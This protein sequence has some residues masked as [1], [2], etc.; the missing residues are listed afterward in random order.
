MAKQPHELNAAT[1]FRVS[2]VPDLGLVCD[3][4]FLLRVYVLRC[5]GNCFYVG[6]TPTN[7]LDRIQSQFEG[8]ASHFCA[9]NR[10]IEVVALLPAKC[11]AIEAA[12]FYGM[13]QALNNK[14]H[15]KLGGFTQ[16]SAKPSPLV[17]MQMEMASPRF[18]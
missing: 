18:A 6:I 3:E 8:T 14:D 9:V 17:V 13:Q 12:L 15:T 16:T 7:K 4:S 2:P 11:E 1:C 10:P 5:E